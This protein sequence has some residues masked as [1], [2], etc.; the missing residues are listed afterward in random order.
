MTVIT[1]HRG[2]FDWRLKQLWRYRDLIMQFVWRDFVSVYKQTVLGPT[3]HVLRPL[4]ATF[5]FTIV[6]RR[7]ASLS[8]DNAPAFLFY[9]TGYIMWSYFAVCLDNISK[10]FISNST[11]L[12]KVYFPRLVIPVSLV[13]SNLVAFGIQLVLLAALLTPYMVSGSI[14]LTVW[15]I[16]FPLLLVILAGYALACGLLICAITTRYR[17]L[18]YLITFGLQLLM[19][20]TPVIYPL[21]SVPQQYRGLLQANP[22]TPLLEAF[23]RG[24]LGVGTV[25]LGHIA[26]SA[27][28]MVALLIVGL[29]MFSRA[30][31]TFVDTV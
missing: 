26:A 5:V 14:R 29:M 3:W 15:V 9:L 30:E 24:V 4:L 6:F 1:P 17:D 11:L 7:I 19:Y 27:I 12:G 25:S 16:G 22:L 18:A 20:L 2:W 31:Q 21:S 28:G 8:T 10:T 23:R 13:I